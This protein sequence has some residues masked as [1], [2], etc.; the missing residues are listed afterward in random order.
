MIDIDRDWDIKIVSNICEKM[1]VQ[2]IWLFVDG[3]IAEDL[4][5]DDWYSATAQCA[6]STMRF[7]KLILKMKIQNNCG[8]SLN[9]CMHAFIVLGILILK[10]KLSITW[11][12]L[13]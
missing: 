7:A 5:T 13:P 2:N 10:F 4:R 3:L 12:K 1:N 11:S 8:T 6:R 9:N